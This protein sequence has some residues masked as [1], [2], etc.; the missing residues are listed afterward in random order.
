MD[1]IACNF[2]SENLSQLNKHIYSCK[3]YNEWFKNY[4]PPKGYECKKC[5]IKFINTEYLEEHDKNCKK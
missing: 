3:Y 1:C 2:K 4:V 5:H